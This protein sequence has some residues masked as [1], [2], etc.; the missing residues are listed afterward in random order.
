M[1]VFLSGCATELPVCERYEV[2]VPEQKATLGI[3]TYPDSW[4][5]NPLDFASV[6]NYWQKYFIEAPAKEADFV[7]KETSWRKDCVSGAWSYLTIG[8]A[9]FI[10]TW[11]QQ[12]CTYSYSLTRRKT[13]KTIALPDIQG[14]SRLYMGWLLMP[15]IFFPNVRMDQTNTMARVPAMIS[16]IEEAA[17]LIYTGDNSL[18]AIE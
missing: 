7:L 3:E 11:G 13:G 15:A 1:I 14:R 17:L 4:G 8:T 5:N 10:P 2:P 12:G 18:Y 9:G 6:R 16:A